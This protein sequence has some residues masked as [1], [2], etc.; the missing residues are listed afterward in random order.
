MKR[1]DVQLTKS[2]MYLFLLVLTV[3]ATVGF[4]GWRTL[5]NNFAV[6]EVGIAGWQNGIIQSVR[7]VP[8]FLSMLVV[9]V[10]LWLKEHRVAALSVMLIGFGVFATGFFP[11]FQGLLFTTFVMSTGFHFFETTNQSLSLQYFN[12]TD[13]PLV[14]T[15]LKSWGALTNISVGGAIYL[16]SGILPF[17]AIYMIFGGLIVLAIIW[18]LTLNPISKDI[19]PQRKSLVLKRD[20]WLFYVLKFF[21][22]ARRQIFVVFA[23][24][25][26]VERYHFT[27]QEIVV[28]FVLN[29]II[30][31]F[32]NP[33]IGK[34]IN[35]FGEKWV[36][37]LEYIAMIAIFLGYAFV[38]DRYIVAGLYIV[39]HIFF[40]FSVAINT[41]FQKTGKPEDIAPSM[42]VG[43]TINHIMAV[44]I[45]VVFGLIWSYSMVIPFVAGAVL[46]L[47]SLYFVRLIPSINK[48]L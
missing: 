46:S 4:Q 16:M 17:K 36:L 45:P 33:Y 2:P 24:F 8:G 32:L 28:L 44:V 30:T 34:A 5:Y 19:V 39:D 48:S 21:A 6:D 14:I 26:L 38:N 11:S 23:V 25:M 1:L 7:E 27:V 42:A 29:N 3:A 10:L 12:K 15:R 40:G 22:G 47:C 20:Y 35:K 9:F 18:I 41:Y 31:F 37:S 13:A 43:F